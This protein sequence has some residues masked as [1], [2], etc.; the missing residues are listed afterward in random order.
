MGASVFFALRDA[1]KNVSEQN[2]LQFDSPATV[3]RIR[4]ICD[5]QFSKIVSLEQRFRMFKFHYNIIKN[6]NLSSYYY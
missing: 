3:E 4:M 6:H 5:D 2:V 1:L